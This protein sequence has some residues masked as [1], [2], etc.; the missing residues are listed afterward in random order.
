MLGAG[1][2]VVCVR[3]RMAARDES[4]GGDKT[5]THLGARPASVTAQ[6]TARLETVAC[7]KL[8]QSWCQCEG[9]AARRCPLG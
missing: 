6:I 5:G 8:L 7:N 3:M 1:D 2:G 4:D 9:K